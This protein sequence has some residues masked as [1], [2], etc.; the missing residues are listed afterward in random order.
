MQ[1]EHDLS[2]GAASLA[3][4]LG[5][6]ALARVDEPI[7]TAT[8]L[9]NAAYTSEAFLELENERLFARTW[10]LA[11]FAHD[12]PDPG[13][14]VPVSVAGK[15]VLL[16]RQ[17]DGAVRAF[18]NVCRHRGARLLS[19]PCKG[20]SSLTCPYHAWRYTLDGKLAAR[21]H[22]HGANKHDVI[23]GG[24][25]E[26]GL[27][28]LRSGQWFDLIFVDLSGEAPP[29]EE[30]LAPMTR[31]L[32]GYDLSVLRHAGHLTFEVEA[33]WKLVHE[34]FIEPYHVF[35]VHPGLLRFAPMDI[36]RP[37]AFEGPCF[38]NDYHYPAPED[39]RGSEDLPHYPG[40]TGDLAQ[41]G[42][43]FHF[44]PSLDIELW[45]DQFAVFQVTPLSPGRTREDI[46]V[47]LI[48]EAAES[49]AYAEARQKVLDMWDGL[50]AEDITVLEMLQAGRHSPGF[51]GGRLSP[52]WDGAPHH[53]ARL[54]ADALRAETPR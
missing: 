28:P 51:D 1:P 3:D 39:G 45:T 53:F 49:E 38:Y 13:D 27:A 4:L 14:A 12:L 30:H 6:E 32:A 50:N 20:R 54:V 25:A 44:F 34:N 46:H 22:F 40:L 43:W 21:P 35:A 17:K 29:L 37:T 47:Y 41:R 7:E 31:R 24:D 42:L 16:V 48:G 36:R 23:E 9:P 52:Y 8:G 10:V 33:N 26:L 5:A 15:P 19:E 2:G 18:H 11:G